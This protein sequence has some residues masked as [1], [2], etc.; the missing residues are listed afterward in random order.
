M[1]PSLLLL[2]CAM[3][4]LQCTAHA[5]VSCSALCAAVCRYVG[6]LDES[7][8][9]IDSITIRCKSTYPNALAL[10]RIGTKAQRVVES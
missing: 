9:S 5:L 1:H 4:P 10:M 3:Q 6:F 7:G 8:D 2:L